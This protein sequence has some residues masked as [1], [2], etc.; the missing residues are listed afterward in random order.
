MM[1]AALARE[2]PVFLF[3]RSFRPD[4]QF[5][6]QLD[7]ELP[8]D[9]GLDPHKQRARLRGAAATLVDQEVRMA[10]RDLDPA[11]ARALEPRRVDQSPCAIAFRIAKST[12]RARQR[13]RL[14]LILAFEVRLL[15][16]LHS[17]WR[18]DLKL[19]LNFKHDRTA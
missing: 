7:P 6:M 4:H 11:F 8:L 3:S 10:F 1:P 9:L 12:A 15:P 5:A 16:R 13:D 19:E 18:F 14:G 17:T 2:R